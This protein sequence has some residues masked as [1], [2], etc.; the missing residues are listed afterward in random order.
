MMFN[1]PAA[2][3]VGEVIVTDPLVPS[4]IEQSQLVVSAVP[5]AGA[6]FLEIHNHSDTPLLLDGYSIELRFEDDSVFTIAMPTEVYIVADGYVSMFNGS[7]ESSDHLYYSLPA[8][9]VGL[10]IVA[11]DIINGDRR[12]A[13]ISDIEYSGSTYSWLKRKS[14]S[15]G[16]GA[17]MDN[18]TK[19]SSPAE[20]FSYGMFVRQGHP[21]V[22]IV[23][24]Y[25]RS[26]DCS[27]T[28]ESVLCG[29][30]IKLYNPT[31][32]RIGL[33]EYRLRS[34]SG[35]SLSGNAFSLDT[36]SAGGYLTVYLRDDGSSLNLTDSG[37]YVWLEDSAGIAPYESTMRSYPS[38]TSG[39][40]GWSWAIHDGTWQWT[41]TP[42]PTGPNSISIPT[43]ET[44]DVDENGNNPMLGECGAGK[45]RNPETNRCKTIQTVN[46]LVPC[47]A[48]QERNPLTNRC[49]SVTLASASLTP[50]G[51][52]QTR[53]PATN[54]CKSTT[55]ATASLVPCKEGQ[56]RNPET[57]RCKS[58]SAAA[59]SLVP[60]KE[61]QE[62][63]PATNRCRKSSSATL[64]ASSG[65]SAQE[66]AGS[67]TKPTSWYMLAGVV[68][69]IAGGYGIWE[70]RSDIAGAT[71]RLLGGLKSP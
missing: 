67:E 69:V 57:N 34:D 11:V 63:N 21:P 6:E 29:D 54:R 10:N 65:L 45:F 50:C 7:A 41:S 18:F 2:S 42:Q 48:G 61:G 71:R 59:S 5:L 12:I 1:A 40:L 13:Q 26:S 51:A 14:S 56:T 55:T 19:K 3:V 62:R 49:K 37:G 25:P 20:L 66:P 22:E 68:G 15:S 53:N 47:N 30:Y 8:E 70:W 33:S 4:E 16:F 35:S 23:E 36:I 17:S 38:A 43:S 39:Y 60:C 31:N 58:T 64:A 46:T 28:D 24:I 9:L 52:G 44:P 27:P 32:N